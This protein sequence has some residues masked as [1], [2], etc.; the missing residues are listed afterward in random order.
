MENTS[1]SFRTTHIGVA[2]YLLTTGAILAKLIRDNP[3]RVLFC[4]DDV[5]P[6]AVGD[7]EHGTATCNAVAY[8]NSMQSLKAKMFGREA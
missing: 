8:Y 7:W 4:L 5:K 1:T 3:H 6:S 2:A